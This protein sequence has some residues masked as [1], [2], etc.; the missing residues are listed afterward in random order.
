MIKK[1]AFLLIGFAVLHGG[2]RPYFEDQ[3]GDVN[4]DLKDPVY[5]QIYEFQDRQEIDSLYAYFYHSTPTY[6]YAAALAFASIKAP[7]AIDSL[8][9]LLDDPVDQVRAAAAYALGQIGDPAGQAPLIEA[10]ESYD[11]IGAFARANR[12]ILE[13]I[14]KCGDAEQL[15]LL[16]SV[17]TYE[18]RDTALLEGQAWGIYRFGLRGI[19]E[20]QG[21]NRMIELASDQSIPASVRLIAS[22]YL[23]RIENISIDSSSAAGLIEIIDNESDARIRMALAVAI[24]KAKTPEALSSLLQ[25]YDQEDDYRVRCNILRAFSN[26]DYADVSDKVMDALKDPNLHVSKR[27]AQYFVEK[28]ESQ[29]ASSYWRSAKDTIASGLQIQMYQAANRY[30]PSY[31]AKYRDAMNSEIRRRFRQAVSPYEKADAIKAMAEYGWNYR[32]IINEGLK[33]THPAVRTSSIQALAQISRLSNFRGF[34][35]EGYRQVNRELARA[36]QEAIESG[37]PALS[38]IAAGALINDDRRFGRYLRDDSLTFI[39]NTMSQL[40]LPKDAEAYHELQKAYAYLREEEAPDPSPIGYNHPINWDI[41]TSLN[42]EP[43]AI[44]RTSKGNIQI[45]LLPKIAPGS[46]ANFI[47]L[48]RD[49]FFDNT[50]FHR[51]VPNFVI[52][53]GCPRGD[54]YGGQNYTIRSELPHLH[55]DR[56]G[57]VGMASSGNHTESTQFFITHSPTP[58]LDGNYT[59]F[60]RVAENDMRVV[61]QIQI[62]DEIEDVVIQ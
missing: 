26:F 13:A 9:L 61:H 28:G 25:L 39:K 2:C 49:N 42:I 11:T 31:Y 29:D 50:S 48:A 8:K 58:H 37:D 43:Q 4:I 36:F 12:A 35:G 46:V 15:R 44:I 45:K 7:E 57:Y 23:Y 20:Q 17:S 38:S 54:G 3:L 52:Q 10:F 22:N 6:R 47:Q 40:E 33:E 5:Q 56:A 16:S 55:Y 32:A 51:V 18:A 41:L 21:T 59:I 27:A 30:L 60:G 62:G 1:I 24:G 14:G 34:F 53:G 19:S